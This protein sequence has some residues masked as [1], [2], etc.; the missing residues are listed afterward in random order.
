M[1]LW[2]PKPGKSLP[3]IMPIS[4]NG[5][6][7]EYR[8]FC[9][10]RMKFYEMMMLGNSSAGTFFTH[11]E[12]FGH[13]RPFVKTVLN[14]SFF[15]RPYSIIRYVY[16]HIFFCPIR[17]AFYS[18]WVWHTVVKIIIILLLLL[19]LTHNAGIEPQFPY[20]KLQKQSSKGESL[21]I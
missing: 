7:H 6:Y 5:L 3:I 9:G 12:V 10:S 18:A 17:V 8:P 15:S 11:P 19:L 13:V 2:P 20:H 21:Q 14:L 1:V 4:S 16:S